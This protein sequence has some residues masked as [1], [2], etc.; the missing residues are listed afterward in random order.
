MKMLYVYDFAARA[1]WDYMLF[2]V[3]V[4]PYFF[5]GAF[6]I[7]FFGKRNGIG[8]RNGT[9]AKGFWKISVAYCSFAILF[10]C[11]S[12][13]LGWNGFAQAKQQMDTM[14]AQTVEGYVENLVTV[15]RGDDSFTL[16][17]VAFEYGTYDWTYG[18]GYY[19]RNAMDGGVITENGQ[20]LRIT[21]LPLK[22]HN[23]ILSIEAYAEDAGP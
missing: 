23:A 7:W 17:G 19:H 15:G 22:G 8:R 11:L 2:G 1:F 4:I 9:K 6:L 21:Y 10:V 14:G 5:F 12:L 18:A 13:T 3:Q 16:N 20:H